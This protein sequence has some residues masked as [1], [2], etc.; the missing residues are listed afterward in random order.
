M[1]RMFEQRDANKDGKL[2][3]DEIPSQM[4]GRMERIDT[5][6]DKAISKAEIEKA[7]SQMGGRTGGGGRPGGAGR[8]GGR[9]G[10]GQPGGDRPARPQAEDE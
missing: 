2:S 5:D 8:P 6:G 9:Q 4:A 7:M 10:G 1:I 3:G